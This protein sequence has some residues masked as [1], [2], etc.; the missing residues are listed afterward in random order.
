MF[1]IWQLIVF[2]CKPIILGNVLIVIY[3]MLSISTLYTY[4]KYSILFSI[5]DYYHLFI[6]WALLS[7]SESFMFTH[8]EKSSLSPR[9][10]FFC[11]FVIASSSHRRLKEFM[12]N[13]D[14]DR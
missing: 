11:L 12:L 2:D 3:L 13:N 5:F 8:I 10:S 7:I 1:K 6:N 9:S 14:Y 4:P